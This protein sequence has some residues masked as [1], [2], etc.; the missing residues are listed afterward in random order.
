MART[1][2]RN[3]TLARQT[4]ASTSYADVLDLSFTPL[5]STAYYLFWSAQF[6]LSLTSNNGRHRLRDD[7]AGATLSNPIH[8]A[9]NTIDIMSVGGIARWTSGPSPA[10]QTFSLEHS[11]DTASMTL[12]TADAYLMA[13]SADATDEFAESTGSSSTTSSTLSDKVALSFT[14]D[15]AG[16]YLVMC[17][18]EI[19][20][21]IPASTNGPA[22]V[23]LDINGL[24]LFDTID[25]YFSQT[26]SQHA[27]WCH[28]AVV[29]LAAEPQGVK[30][31]YAASD[32][33]T[34]V[35]IR[36]ARILAMR[37]DSFPAGHTAQNSARQSTTESAPQVAAGAT[38]TAHDRDYLFIGTALIDHSTSASTMEA[39]V[40]WDG[41][42]RSAFKR[43]QVSSSGARRASYVA[44]GYGTLA[45]GSR[46][47]GLDWWRTS[48]GTASVTNAF[49]GAFLLDAVD[50][51]TQAPAA[52][53]GLSGLAPAV[54]SDGVAI[55]P[56][57]VGVLVALVPA[58]GASINLTV[59]GAAFALAGGAPALAMGAAV[60]VPPSN[61][62]ITGRAPLARVDVVLH[63]GKAAVTLSGLALVRA[64]PTW[65]A[66]NEN[67]SAW[68][69]R[70]PAASTW[71]PVPAA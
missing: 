12:G 9:P 21:V 55:I 61:R 69:E 47:I 57:G 53:A 2:H 65:R 40:D 32:N 59:P 34:T 3:N 54:A 30:I 43:R 71:T 20:G 66:I 49:I 15:S 11:V 22:R 26:S 45:A 17:S 70:N 36:Q 19:N 7:T 37:L 60:Q 13:I 38:F 41:A 68:T 56:P 14:P 16:D 48:S 67:Q 5:P 63:A 8:R 39:R 27:S 31:R 6:D 52:T 10:P 62:A 46:T 51:E 25:G 42:T 44:L 24:E 23:L 4:T 50:A 29:N 33:A 64:G 18:C 58:I 35:Q 28:G 1:W